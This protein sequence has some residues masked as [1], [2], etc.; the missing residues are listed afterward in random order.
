MNKFQNG[1]HLKVVFI[2]IED[3]EPYPRNARKHPESQLRQLQKNI[4]AHGWTTPIHVAGKKILAGHGRCL[5]A[6]RIGLTK[7][8]AIDLSHLSP[9]QQREHI[10]SENA[11]ALQ[12]TWDLQ[13][14]KLELNELNMEGIDMH[15]T[16]L[17]DESLKEFMAIGVS[18]LNLDDDDEPKDSM[19]TET[20]AQ[21]GDIW[22]L[23]KNCLEVGDNET[24]L[25][26]VDK[27]IRTWQKASGQDAERSRDSVT[28]KE[29]DA[30]NKALSKK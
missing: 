22:R 24:D 12:S 4:E 15:L 2:P 29:L 30:Y 11:I 17:D 18:D 6:K 20:I 9:L 7:V 13:F 8:P 16:G 1:E 3:L 23:G 28:F 19:P 14:L 21:P 27:A 5:V 26:S 25:Q 10:L